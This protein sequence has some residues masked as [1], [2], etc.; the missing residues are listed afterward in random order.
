MASEF[1]KMNDIEINT[2]KS[3]AVI[4]NPKN[5][6]ATLILQNETV[7]ILALGKET[8]YLSIYI[9]SEGINKPT[10]I[11]IKE[12]IHFITSK[13]TSKAITNKQV[14]YL[15]HNILHPIIEYRTQII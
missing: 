2:R 4:I 9:S 7:P 10:I 15:I 3:D 14:H 5:T 8:G 1:Y 12:E 6:T 13:I 11:K